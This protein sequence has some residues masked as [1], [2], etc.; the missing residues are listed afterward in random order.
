MGG[1]LDIVKPGVV[2]GDDVKKI[3][4]YA[5]ENEFAIPAVNVVG[6]DSINAVLEAARDV[7][8]PSRSIPRGSRCPQR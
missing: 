2:F 4:Q 5:K 1:V 7:N 6:T 8:S 3:Y